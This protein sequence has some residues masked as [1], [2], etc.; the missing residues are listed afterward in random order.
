MFIW[1]FCVSS[2]HGKVTLHKYKC[3]RIVDIDSSQWVQLASMKDGAEKLLAVKVPCAHLKPYRS[4]ILHQHHPAI[5]TPPH[6]PSSVPTVSQSPPSVPTLSSTTSDSSSAQKK[7]DILSLFSELLRVVLH[8]LAQH[9]LHLL[10][11][12]PHSPQHLL[13]SPP[14]FSHPIH[15]YSFCI[16][17]PLNL[18]LFY[19]LFFIIHFHSLCI[20]ILCLHSRNVGFNVLMIVIFFSLQVPVDQHAEELKSSLSSWPSCSMQKC[21]SLKKSPCQKLCLS[22]SHIDNCSAL[23]KWQFPAVDG[24]QRCAVSQINI[25]G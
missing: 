19:S 7:S 3:F 4:S 9:H 14:P 17:Y 13:F 11:L 25:S 2:C 18:H 10:L 8:S 15:C 20:N 1:L 23:L 24:L 6:A 21:P 22:D 5:H 12:L 16:I